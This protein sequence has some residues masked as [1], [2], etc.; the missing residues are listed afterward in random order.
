[1]HPS[2]P[3]KPKPSSS[4]QREPAS[5]ALVA[6]KVSSPKPPVSE[7][8][9]PSPK[10]VPEMSK[11]EKKSSYMRSFSKRLS[12]IT[13][14]DTGDSQVLREDPHLKF[15]ISEELY[16]SENITVF[17]VTSN[18]SGSTFCMKKI[19]PRDNEERVNIFEEANIHLKN[20]HENIIKYHS[21]FSFDSFFW[22]VQEKYEGNL[23]D[24]LSSHAG[25]IPEKFMS[26]VCKE[27]LTGLDYLHSSGRIHRD[28]KSRNVVLFRNGDVKLGDF[29]YAAQI[30][31]EQSIAQ[32]NP[33]WMA[34]EL[35][36]GKDYN[37]SVDLWSLGI[38]LLE[39]AEGAPPYD[40]EPFDVVMDNIIS[41]PPP[42]LKNKLKWSKDITNFLGLCLRKQAI[43]RLSAKSLLMHPFIEEND[44]QTMKEQFSEYY[45]QIRIN[46]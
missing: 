21:V 34:P 39:M 46:S 38:L 35:I 5:P 29:G 28:I 30:A 31:D 41:Q 8:P 9:K 43:E 24:L 7:P 4:S 42:K 1:M 11:E 15:S 12:A 3:I 13:K 27:V 26:Y 14:Q 40:G 17:S 22:I 2:E 19:K 10:Q 45:M 33:S 18:S 36:L 6:E 16:T 23:F 44:E 37:E 20:F 25:F 32:Y